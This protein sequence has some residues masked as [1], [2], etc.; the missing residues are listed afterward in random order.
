MWNKQYKGRTLKHYLL[1]IL[2]VTG[3]AATAALAP[4]MYNYVDKSN[5]FDWYKNIM[6]FV[7]AGWFVMASL[8][9]CIVI[10]DEIRRIRNYDK[11][12]GNNQ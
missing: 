2:C 7:S 11:S 8:I 6:L 4:A 1:F 12:D 9:T 5:T 3:C 10:S